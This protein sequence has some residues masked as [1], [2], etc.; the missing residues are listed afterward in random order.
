MPES[1]DYSVRRFRMGSC[2][3]VQLFDSPAD[4]RVG[5]VPEVGNMAYE[6]K[7]KGKDVLWFPFSSPGDLRAQPAMCGI[8]FLAPWA[9]R[10][11]GPEYWA[12]GKKYGINAGLGNIRCDPQGKPIHGLLR[13][14]GLWDVVSAGADAN[15]AWATSRLDFWKYPDLMAQFPFAHSMRMTYRLSR[16]E[17]EVEAE[18]ENL[19]AEP[20]PVAVGFHPYLRV[21][22][23]PRDEWT[24]HIAARDR[25][26]LDER[27][28][29]TGERTPV[30]FEDAQPLAGLDLDHVFAGLVRDPDGKAR[31][32][33]QGRHQR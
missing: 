26:T 15:S 25:L 13:Y 29:P 9:N 7:V 18:I 28:I 33:V 21:D 10:L 16:G 22:D 32:H 6:I 3:L 12:N 2:E 8:P 4:L 19:A 1:A 24:V 11:D 17:L 5:L 20:M 30:Q 23:A 14:S 27:L 31:F